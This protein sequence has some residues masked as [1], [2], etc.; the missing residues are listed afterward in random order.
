M[1]IWAYSFTIEATGFGLFLEAFSWETDLWVK[2]G[3]FAVKKTQNW[4][5][6]SVFNWK[7]TK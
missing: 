2:L 4:E 5:E 6:K 7:S 1:I 3:D